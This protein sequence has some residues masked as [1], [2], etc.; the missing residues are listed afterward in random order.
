MRTRVISIDL[1]GTILDFRTEMS[2][3]VR[4]RG[5][6]RQYAAD[7][8]ITDGELVDR[9]YISAANHFYERYEN[10]AVT[11]TPRERLLHQLELIGIKPDSSSFEPLL[12]DVQDAILDNPPPLAPNVENALRAL[13]AEFILVVVS[14]TGFSPGKVIRKLF[15]NRG[16]ARYFTDYSF[17]DENGKSKPDPFAFTSV[18]ERVGAKPSEFVHIGDTEWSDIKGARNLGGRACLYVGLSDKWLDGTEADFILH[19]WADVSKLVDQI[20]RAQSG[21]A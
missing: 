19:D 11:L 10:E 3:S 4:R 21:V 18:L 16:I 17:S 1:W 8:G 6:V 2:A 5:L 13:S 20:E 9:A 14:D 7:N 12:E 15:Q